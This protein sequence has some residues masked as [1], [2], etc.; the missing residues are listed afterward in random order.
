MRTTGSDPVQ[1]ARSLRSGL[2]VQK[3]RFAILLSKCHETVL[4][5]RKIIATSQNGLVQ[6]KVIR[7]GGQVSRR[8]LPG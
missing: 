8:K 5:S 7:F 6:L 1:E 3:S 4:E 2:L